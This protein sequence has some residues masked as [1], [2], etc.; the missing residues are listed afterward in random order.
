MTVQPSGHFIFGA[1]PLAHLRWTNLTN[2][3][4]VLNS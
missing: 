4:L 2:I 1:R 3:G